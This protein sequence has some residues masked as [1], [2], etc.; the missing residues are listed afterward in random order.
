MESFFN[1]HKYLIDNI[2]QNLYRR[3]LMDRI[4]W[5]H[6]LIGIKGTRGVGKTTFLLQYAHENYDECDKKCLYINLNHFYFTECSLIQFAGKFIARGG[7][8]LLVDQVFKYPEWSK[9]L[10]K[11]YDL[12]PNLKIVFTGSS[13]MKLKETN[14]Y[15]GDV[16]HSYNLNGFSFR[17]YLAATIKEELPSL[18]IE[19][20]VN[21][22]KVLARNILKTIDVEGYFTD[23][24]HHGYYPFF[25]EKRN[26]SEN[27]LKTM[28][29]MLE[30]DILYIQEIEQSY[31][32]KIRKLFYLLAIQS[33][34]SP[35]VSQLSLDCG[36]SR[37]T[38]MNYLKYLQDAR[39]INMLYKKGCDFPK[40][41]DKVYLNNTNIMFPTRRG[42]VDNQSLNETFFYNQVNVTG[43]VKKGERKNQFFVNDKYYFRIEL[44]NRKYTKSHS[45]FVVV[46]SIQ[47]E[48]NNVIP[49]W[50]FGFLY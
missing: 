48:E 43:S 47:T 22:H 30:V 2:D 28:N 31:L 10:R 41:P 19:Q 39:L 13:V 40:K 38:V 11:C 15:I 16:A 49:L 7:E 14:L 44:Q 8:T 4:D 29:M 36:V 27:L 32:T 34:A 35:N 33:P 20:I 21:N 50:L 45:Q 6:R 26:Y 18:T 46:D 9:E 3:D 17:E 42:N 12:Y 1:T 23:Y 5:S 24:I 37:A 25:F